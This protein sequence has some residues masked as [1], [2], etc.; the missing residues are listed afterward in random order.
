MSTACAL[1]SPEGQHDT[2]LTD[3][4][5]KS[6]GSSNADEHEVQT[7]QGE[8]IV[9]F[10]LSL[11]MCIV[12]NVYADSS[13]CFLWERT[14][15]KS[16]IVVYAGPLVQGETMVSLSLHICICGSPNSR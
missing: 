9:S 7:Q 4:D 15:Q 1:A 8:T 14:L 10:S 16:S 6:S 2:A 3:T 11:H 13:V 12:Y 5:L